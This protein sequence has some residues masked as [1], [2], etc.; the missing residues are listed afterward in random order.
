MIRLSVEGD[1]ASTRTYIEEGF[2]PRFRD[3][4]PVEDHLRILAEMR[5]RTGGFDLVEVR[6]PAE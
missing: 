6:D 4:S 3:S 1:D 5:E 2:A